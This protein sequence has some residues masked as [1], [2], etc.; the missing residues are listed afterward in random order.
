MNICGARTSCSIISMACVNLGMEIC[1]KAENMYIVGIITSPHEPSL[2]EL[3]HYMQPLMDDMV[4]AWE[5]GIHF[6]RTSLYLM[7]RF[8]HS[9]IAV[10]IN[11][12]PAAWKASGL[13]GHSMLA[14]MNPWVWTLCDKHKLCE[15]ATQWRDTT[16]S[17]KQE[18]IFHLHGVCWS[19][20]WRLSYSNP[21]CQL[22]V[23]SMHCI[24]K[25]SC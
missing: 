17:S 16:T 5:R 15:Y 2:T 10:S 11:D 3:N 14:L 24:L 4:V 7:G 21:T 25:R 20:L 18:K 19:E 12:L 23:D 6:S 22:I 1:Y 9:A 8:T 13:A